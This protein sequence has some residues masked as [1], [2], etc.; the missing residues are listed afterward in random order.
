MGLFDI[1]KRKEKETTKIEPKQE[2]KKSFGVNIIYDSESKFW[3]RSSS[4]DSQLQAFFSEVSEA[5]VVLEK[6][7]TFLK[8]CKFVV[9]DSKGN[10][11]EDNMLNNRLKETN[12]FQSIYDIMGSWCYNLEVFGESFLYA[13]KATMRGVYPVSIFSLPSNKVE[14]TYKNDW[15]KTVDRLSIVSAYKY[16]SKLLEFEN[17]QHTR[18][19]DPQDFE[20]NVSKLELIK[21]DIE[22][23]QDASDLKKTVYVKKGAIG[24][25]SS[26]AS[27]G[28]G[29]IPLSTK[30]KEEIKK[31]YRE[32][33]GIKQ[34]QS[35]IILTDTPLEWQ[36]MS[37][38]LKD[39]M[40]EESRLAS[41]LIC[42]D[43][44]GMD[45]N[46]FSFVGGSTFANLK[47]GMKSTYNNT[48]IPFGE[49]FANELTKLLELD[50][51]G[52]RIEVDYSHLD[53]LKDDERAEAD[54]KEVQSNMIINLLNNQLI[55]ENE[56]KN[57]LKDLQITK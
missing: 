38:P 23:I 24:I 22:L 30:A 29:G 52:K 15:Y 18:N 28:E 19:I 39:F 34:G 26:N 14:T 25:L 51:Q 56:A 32:S 20:Q 17:V 11:L 4:T 49:R 57:M 53:F 13:N 37:F 44:F 7:I 48:I 27:D 21:R 36:P 47:E 45:K 2:V 5:Q 10:V 8:S 33:H 55:N 50:K 43:A 54:T 41:F 46:V 1:F 42:I 3:T 35:A 31:E 16:E 6:K 12:P 9:K 40:L